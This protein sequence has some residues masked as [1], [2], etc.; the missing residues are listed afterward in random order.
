MTVARYPARMGD[1]V[2]GRIPD[3][4]LI[5]AGTWPIS[6]GVWTA[7]MED[8]AA[9][10]DALSCPAVRN[11]V[12][13][14]GHDDPRFSGEP[15]VGWVGGMRVADDGLT[16]LG[17][18]EGMPGWL[19]D[20]AASAYP[21]RSIEGQYA[22]KCQIGH[23]H[24]FVVEAVALLG[25][26]PPGVGTLQSL[27][28]VAALYGVQAAADNDGT[29]V[30]FK[31]EGSHM[32]QVAA[33]VTVEDMRRT[34]YEA[35]PWDE[36]IVEV[37]LDPLELITCSDESG[38]YFR[39]PVTATGDTV[40]FGDKVKVMRRWEDAPA[41]A[42]AVAAS[43]T[44]YA[45]R[46]ESRPQ[47]PSVT[48]AAGSEKGAGM[49]PAKLRDALGLPADASDVEVQ[50]ALA[51]SGITTPA[52]TDTPA[53]QTTPTVELPEGLVAID[54]ETLAGLQV[55]AAAGQAADT[56]LRTQDRDDAITSAVKAGKIPPSRREHYAK[57]WDAD[58][59]GTREVLASL[60]PGLVPVTPAGYAGAETGSDLDAEYAALFGAT[61]QEG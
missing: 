30:T 35:A 16:L 10:V 57:A 55:A 12:L 6:T 23:T 56:R 49:D 7:T 44:V 24:P 50:A 54:A 41:P 52:A 31:V 33:G 21:D 4:E 60:A 39:V 19:A 43:R 40:T 51:A 36:W 38:A 11:P 25:V 46:A 28:D 42:E 59:E 22:F 27:N 34:Y 1:V 26:T 14:L 45:S 15:S 58:P 8:L 13:K 32:P 9:A 5:H 2:L 18:F 61:T 3:V 47:V 17:D 48:V 37:S 53:P 20:V 29:R